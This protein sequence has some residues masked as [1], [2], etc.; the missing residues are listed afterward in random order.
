VAEEPFA[1]QEPEDLPAENLGQPRVVQTRQPV[2][3]PRPVDTALG[4]QEMQVRVEVLKK[5][6]SVFGIVKTTS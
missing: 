1:D 2:E 3:D 4:Q 5:I 6:L